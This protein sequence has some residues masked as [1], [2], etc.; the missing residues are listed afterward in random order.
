MITECV[1]PMMRTIDY[2]TK[3]QIDPVDAFNEV[4]TLDY[5]SV[6]IR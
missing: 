1:E 2:E 4:K 5:L 6:G 3:S